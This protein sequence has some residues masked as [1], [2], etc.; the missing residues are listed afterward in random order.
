MD[1]LSIA[2]GKI[3]DQQGHPA[4]LRGVNIGGWMNMENFING[5]PGSESRQRAVLGEVLGRSKAAFFFERYLDYFFNEQDVQFLK[6]RGV[7]AI[8]LPLNYRHFESDLA[9][10]EYIESGFAR[11]EQ[12]LSW[13]EKHGIYAILDLHSVQGWQNGDWHCDNSSRHALFWMHRQF[14]D[15]FV[16][17]WQEFARRY[18]DR[19]VVA[20][21]NIMNEPLGNAPF[22]RF[23][24]D[25]DYQPDWEIVNHVYRRVVDAVRSI[26]ARHIILLEGDN[27]STLFRGLEPP[28]DA[29]LLY[30]NHN[31]IPV[32]TAEL[33]SYPV[34]LN[35]NL[36]DAAH[37]QQQFSLTEGWRYASQY[38]VPLL[39]GEF[40]FNAR[41]SQPGEKPQLRAFADQMQAYNQYQVHW[42]F[43]TYKDAGK[44]GW[45]QFHP[46]SAYM[47]AIRPVLDA[48]QTLR[49]DTGWLGGFP[50][51]IAVHLDAL[52]ECILSF[53][54][55][56]NPATNR[57][58]LAQAAMSTYTA[59]QL[60]LLYAQQFAGKSET[61]LDEILQSLSL[62][63]CLQ[64]SELNKLI[65]DGLRGQEI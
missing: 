24:P 10:F 53:I 61:E 27:Y 32:S 2:N 64:S 55:E 54:P 22:G 56:V 12:V 48:K 33:A 9:P 44:M 42:T 59:D 65:S 14:Q 49:P 63:H 20:A 52:S 19:A 40:G 43:W 23:L 57:R 37:I 7:S 50:P 45:V 17:L 41:H 60:Q 15:R 31:Y 58:Y 62:E 5:Y 28:F 26:D 21:Y 29:N 34:D 46:E 25:A 36:W 6:A 38:N 13:C 39:V 51:E 11:L 4:W 16:A 8:R 35:E 18:K 1:F 30:S 47:R 3:V